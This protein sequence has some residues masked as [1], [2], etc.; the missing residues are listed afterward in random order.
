MSS[1]VRS[2]TSSKS[3]FDEEAAQII[4][5]LSL[6]TPASDHQS[7]ETIN[8]N[9]IQVSNYLNSALLNGVHYYQNTTNNNSTI[10]N[11]NNSNAKMNNHFHQSSQSAQHQPAL[12]GHL[13]PPNHLPYQQT[14]S[15]MLNNQSKLNNLNSLKAQ[16]EN[17]Y[18]EPN[19]D[20]NLIEEHEFG[21]NL[22][23]SATYAKILNKAAR[24]LQQR[25]F[26]PES[27]CSYKAAYAL[28][29]TLAS[30]PT[31][32][33][34]KN[35]PNKFPVSHAFKSSNNVYVNSTVPAIGK[36]PPN[37]QCP[38]YL[39]SNQLL[40]GSLEQF[41]K[42]MMNDLGTV[43]AVP[44]NYS[45]S[46]H[47]L[48]GG[49]ENSSDQLANQ[50]ANQ[51]DQHNSLTNL[52][53]QQRTRSINGSLP[54]TQ[55]SAASQL[56]NLISTNNLNSTSTNNIIDLINKDI[57]TIINSSVNS[58]I[59]GISGIRSNQPPPTNTSSYSAIPKNSNP[60]NSSCN[61]SNNGPSAGGGLASGQSPQQAGKLNGNLCNSLSSLGSSG[62]CSILTATPTRVDTAVSTSTVQAS[63]NSNGCSRLPP[64]KPLPP[65]P[66]IYE[67]VK[68]GNKKA[69]APPPLVAVMSS[70][71]TTSIKL[72]PA[73]AS[74]NASHSHQN[75][76][77]SSLNSISLN[78]QCLNASQDSSSTLNSLSTVQQYLAKSQFHQ[79][80]PMDGHGARLREQ[81]CQNLLVQQSETQLAGPIYANAPSASFLDKSLVNNS[82]LSSTINSTVTGQQT[83]Q[84]PP[85]SINKSPTN[86]STQL[87]QQ[88][89]ASGQSLTPS[90]NQHLQQASTNNL[91]SA[92]VGQQQ[93]CSG[94]AQSS[95]VHPYPQ[96]ANCLNRQ[97]YLIQT[98]NTANGSA[99]AVFQLN[100]N[101]SQTTQSPPP[102]PLAPKPIHQTAS[103]TN[104]DNSNLISQYN[105]NHQFNN[106]QKVHL[107]S[108][109][110]NQL[111]GLNGNT[112]S[113]VG[114]QTASA[115]QPQLQ[116]AN[117]QTSKG[118]SSVKSK[119]E[120]LLKAIE[121]EMDNVPQGEFFGLCHTC[122]ERV[123]G[124]E[125]A[126]QAMGKW[127]D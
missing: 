33:L 77:S 103:S 20:H 61:I 72:H 39:T 90:P 114:S 14:N 43:H 21:D 75:S 82:V 16:I 11:N 7:Q 78:S 45:Q 41:S 56:P 36:P 50:L 126:C 9:N 47:A 60:S 73:T 92:L 64:N 74:F 31:T 97:P 88:L 59:S 125:K 81:L 6:F 40:K 107:S 113:L 4:H 24:Q 118:H 98:T 86:S 26:P 38:S 32:Q 96:S 110:V 68:S 122:G 108:L 65:V 15:Q 127:R 80:P 94:V 51:L 3:S 69:P 34:S 12:K 123:E 58:T 120:D 100:S 42:S 27:N 28:N 13:P 70:I 25:Q 18:Y 91:S 30:N 83:M 76:G 121:D 57:N 67:N 63:G 85:Y 124:A 46:E 117:S 95:A 116:Q 62:N 2:S 1:S 111:T 79:H 84:P 71:K 23:C 102:L 48:S 89:Q 106:K 109:S 112:G 99:A 49:G 35:E 17:G 53:Q 119:M 22:E 37:S 87:M 115:L 55:S 101:T 105:L 29:P 10:K 5:E 52:L 19:Y 66:P 44:Y 8:N 93:Q 54:A 104:L